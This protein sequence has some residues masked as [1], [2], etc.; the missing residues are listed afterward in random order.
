[1]TTFHVNPNSGETGACKARLG[2]CPF[3]TSED[4]YPSAADARG[5]YEAKQGGSFSSQNE[6]SPKAQRIMDKFLVEALT[7]GYANSLTHKELNSVSA[8]EWDE[9][10]VRFAAD[11]E[12]A[13]T[14]YRAEDADL[15]ARGE[16]GSKKLEVL[17]AAWRTALVRRDISVAAAEVSRDRVIDGVPVPAGHSL[18][19]AVFDLKGNFLAPARDTRVS[20]QKVTALDGSTIEYRASTAADPEKRRA[21]E[22]AKGFYTGTAVIPVGF[23]VTERYG[24]RVKPAYAE[25][26]KDRSLG[27][28]VDSGKN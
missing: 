1:M 12:S 9:L 20:G 14:A 17:R 6:P 10:S 22:A 2:R 19:R 27:S 4:H 7:G 18:E 13:E 26:R 15:K 11:A 21:T 25:L 28:P 8:S 16:Y 23:E 24:V 5:A 3:G